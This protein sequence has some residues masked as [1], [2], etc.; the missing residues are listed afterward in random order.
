[1]EF[2]NVVTTS[3]TDTIRKY[4]KMSTYIIVIMFVND[5][6]KIVYQRIW[7]MVSRCLWKIFDWT[8]L[9]RYRIIAI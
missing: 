7:Q 1:V 9:C 5:I 2:E 4:K 8:F 3:S 6:F